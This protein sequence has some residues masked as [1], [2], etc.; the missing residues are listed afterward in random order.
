MIEIP[1][2]ERTAD[3]MPSGLRSSMHGWSTMPSAR[4]R[5]LGERAGVGVA[6]P[7]DEGLRLQL[8]WIHR[9]APRPTMVGRHD[10]HQLVDDGTAAARAPTSAIGRSTNPTSIAP[11]TTS[12][13]TCTGDRHV[14]RDLDARVLLPEA[15]D[16][17]G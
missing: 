14:E 9:V 8:T 12:E 16:Y 10:E 2:P 6:L 17:V 13:A 11:A 4:E 15:S 3:L 1:R 5:R 7:R